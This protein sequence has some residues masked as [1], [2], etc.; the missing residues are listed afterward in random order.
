MNFHRV[1]KV[2]G[3]IFLV[4]LFL[5]GVSWFLL[6]SGI[7]DPGAAR[8]VKVAIPP[9]DLEVPVERTYRS[10]DDSALRHELLDYWSARPLPPL[11]ENLMVTTP[12]ILLASLF[13]ETRLDEVNSYIRSLE[14]RGVSGSSWWMNPLGNYN[15]TQAALIPM[16]Y[17]FGDKP[18]ILYPETLKHLDEVLIVEEGDGFNMS[19]PRTLGLIEDTEN[20]ILMTEG[21]RYLK[22]RWLASRG[23]TDA[24]FDNRKNGMED[25]LA[26]YLNEMYRYGIY[27][28]N[29][30][31]Y[32]AYT[33]SALLNLEAFAEGR[34][35]ALSRM[36]LDRMNLEYAL[37]S[38]NLR[39]HPPI[40]RQYSKYNVTAIN[41][42]YHS[43]AMKAWISFYSESRDI[44][45]DLAIE[46]GRHIA[47]WAAIMPY[48]PADKVI[49]WSLVK[50]H[51][52]FVKIGRGANSC[53]EIY[54]GDPSFLLSAGGAN[55]GR[56]SLI[57]PRP[58]ILFTHD[59]ETDLSDVFHMMGP[60]EDFMDWNNTGVYK[61]FAVAAGPVRIPA[62]G[63]P[64]ADQD[65]WSVFELSEDHFLVTF[66]TQNLGIMTISDRNGRDAGAIL[67]E[68]MG[69]NPRERVMAGNFKQQ[70]GT[71][72]SFDEKA[73]NHLWVIKSVNGVEANRLFESWPAF[74]SG[75]IQP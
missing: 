21:T 71:E 44:P 28:F 49:D 67:R 8:Q 34:V 35:Q 55:Q 73:P 32:L 60:G 75:I 61:R 4:V 37:G 64:L 63:N 2:L 20:H 14:P 66:S 30:D 69:P 17:F 9:G 57:L 29:S 58:I 25:K 10:S 48:R 40:R 16:L 24:R 47:L 68:M 3:L 15:F 22:N 42:D 19:V 12:R 59:D 43:A 56:R 6:W 50:P 62:S 52:Y 38:F 65:E 7:V 13:N 41:R 33:L 11:Q 54:S 1:F 39:R 23:E 74:T 70:D 31:P 45:D 26:G 46:R 18:H 5:L 51:P 53:P 36:L 27:E 72:I